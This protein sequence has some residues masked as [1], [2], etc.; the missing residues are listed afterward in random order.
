MTRELMPY[1]E[2]PAI[3]IVQS[4]QFFDI[5]REHFNWLQRA[6]L[7]WFA[8]LAIGVTGALPLAAQGHKQD[9]A[10]AWIQLNSTAIAQMPSKVFGL[11]RWS[12]PSRRQQRF[13]SGAG[14]ATPWPCSPRGRCSRRSSA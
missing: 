11:R 4:P 8:G 7:R 13:C 14:T 2:D 1:F 6:A 9:S 5:K 10:I 12:R 3:G